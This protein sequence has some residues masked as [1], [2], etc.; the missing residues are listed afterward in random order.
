MTLSLSLDNAANTTARLDYA[1]VNASKKR[2][3]INF[4]LITLKYKVL[5]VNFEIQNIVNE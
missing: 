4:L 5:F 1:N 3:V 2:I